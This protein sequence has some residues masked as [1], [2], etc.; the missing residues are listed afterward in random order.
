MKSTSGVYHIS[1]IFH[2]SLRQS[3]R[4]RATAASAILVFNCG[5][6]S[7]FLETKLQRKLYHV[8][9]GRCEKA[10]F[11]SIPGF[12]QRAR[13]YLPSQLTMPWMTAILVSDRSFIFSL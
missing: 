8:F 3:M 2:G 6:K 5:A 7:A 10:L 13:K 1:I 4:E 9:R 12:V 11:R